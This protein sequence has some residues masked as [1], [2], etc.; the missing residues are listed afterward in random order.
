MGKLNRKPSAEGSFS[1]SQALFPKMFYSRG[2]WTYFG[3]S[4]LFLETHGKHRDTSRSTWDRRR[5]D[6]HTAEGGMQKAALTK[7]NQDT[8]SVLTMCIQHGPDF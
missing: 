8:L 2:L 1:F 6:R 4:D 7:E 3:C 5:K